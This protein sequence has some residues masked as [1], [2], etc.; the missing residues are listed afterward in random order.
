[1]LGVIRLSLLYF[2]LFLL[3]F[4]L[5]PSSIC[6]ATSDYCT[7]FCI[8]FLSTFFQNLFSIWLHQI[9][10]KPCWCNEDSFWFTEW[11][12][13]C[14]LWKLLFSSFYQPLFQ[15][16]F[17][18]YYLNHFCNSI[19]R[20]SLLYFLLFLFLFLFPLF[21]SHLPFFNFRLYVSHSCFLFLSTLQNL[22]L[23]LTLSDI[24]LLLTTLN[25]YYWG[26][27][28]FTFVLANFKTST[29]QSDSIR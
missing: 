18:W 12:F 11:L 8:P 23:N 16:D 4:L 17:I 6:L 28:Y 29:F 19:I 22:F 24:T 3:L 9:L 25:F 2:Q 27:L 14:R 5:P 26:Y 7:C 21:G 13:I 15:S 20:L 1:M 10:L